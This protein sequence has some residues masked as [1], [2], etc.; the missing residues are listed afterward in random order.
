MSSEFSNRHAE[1]VFTS[2]MQPGFQGGT[3]ETGKIS[4]K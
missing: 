2:Q 3:D 4:L 1:Q